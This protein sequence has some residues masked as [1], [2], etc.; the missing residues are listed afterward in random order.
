M[1]N[2]LYFM[3]LADT[4]GCMH[5]E[6]AMPKGQSNIYNILIILNKYRI[7]CRLTLADASKLRM[8]INKKLVDI[9]LAVMDGGEI[10]FFPKAR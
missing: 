2:L 7:D 9:S 8:S 1:I 5:E 10:A 4:I 6:L 3:K